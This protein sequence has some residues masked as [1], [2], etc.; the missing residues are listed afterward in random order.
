MLSCGSILCSC[1]LGRQPERQVF[2]LRWD[3]YPTVKGA[4]RRVELCLALKFETDAAL[5]EFRAKP[6]TWQVIDFWPAALRPCELEVRRAAIGDA[7]G[8][9]DRA[10]GN[11]QGA[12]FRRVGREFVDY[13]RI[14]A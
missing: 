13:Q 6:A 2:W 14:P 7:P 1:T 5:D 8:D 11:R 9:L 3:H 4:S 12:V 10:V